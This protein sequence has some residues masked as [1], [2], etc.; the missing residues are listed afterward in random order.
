[1]PDD[2]T[3]DDSTRR[4]LRFSLFLQGFALVFMGGAM[5]VRASLIGW[6]TVTF[7]FAAFVLVIVGALV[8]TVNRLR[9]G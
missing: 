1:M 5:I 6:D 4:L 2:S 8:W 3:L 9:A 7:V